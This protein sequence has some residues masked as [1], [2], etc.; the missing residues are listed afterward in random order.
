MKKK[1]SPVAGV[2]LVEILIGIVISMIMMAAMFT[3]YQAVNN[4]YS[5]VIDRAK[6]S[7]TGRGVIGMLVK[8]IRLAGFKY[9]DD[10][11]K[12]PTNY[13]PILITKSTGSGSCDKIEIMYSDRRVKQGTKPRAYEYT[14]YKITYECKASN[15]V[16]KKQIKKLM[17]LQF[18]NQ[19]VNGVDQIGF[20]SQ[21]TDDL[22]YKDE[23]I[24]DHVQDFVLIPVDEKGKIIN[25]VPTTLTGSNK[26]RV[27]DILLSLRSQSPFY[28]QQKQIESY[29]LGQKS[30]TTFKDKFLREAIIVSANTRNM[31]LE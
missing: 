27:V 29:S 18:T 10:V 3:S 13:V 2:T 7:Q 25:P 6:I 1:L 21:S 16:D 22:I 8:D 19:K 20:P 24:V 26:I 31:G 14:T 12:S 17:L 5:Q 15:I 4:S 30:N 11:S 9:F 28:K 23:M